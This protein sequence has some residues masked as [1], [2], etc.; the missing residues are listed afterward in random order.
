MWTRHQKHVCNTS[1]IKI[2]EPWCWYSY[3]VKMPLALIDCNFLL[4]CW[5]S[6]H[7]QFFL[8]NL[9]PLCGGTSQFL[10]NEIYFC[11]QIQCKFDMKNHVSTT[12]PNMLEE[13]REIWYPET[14]FSFFLFLKSGSFF[15]LCFLPSYDHTVKFIFTLFLESSWFVEAAV[16]ASDSL[17]PF[18]EKKILTFVKKPYAQTLFGYVSLH[19]VYS[20]NNL[21]MIFSI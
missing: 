10:S 8:Q 14:I 11:L 4:I 1:W 15:V 6:Y 9:T 17:A 18:G 2:M 5:H 19:I 20:I 12:I 13:E 3:L 7:F 16:V 21:K